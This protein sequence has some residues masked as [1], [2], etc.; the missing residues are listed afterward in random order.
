[1]DGEAEP[2]SGESTDAHLAGCVACRN[3]LQRAAV[4][5]RALRVRPASAVPDLAPRVLAATS[6][7]R[8]RRGLG[9]RIAL[10]CVAVAQFGLG[11]AEALGWSTGMGHSGQLMGGMSAHLFNESTCWNLALAAGLAWVAW[12]ADS[13]G[14]LLPVFGGF[15]LLLTGYCVHDLVTGD[16]TVARVASHGLLV[17]GFVLM[18]VVDRRYGRSGP[19]HSHRGRPRGDLPTGA[20]GRGLDDVQTSEQADGYVLR[21]VNRHHAA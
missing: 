11:A 8:R 5:N 18:V 12:R 2:V 15:L 21:P 1:M 20:D 13:V 19:P 6:T 3:W 9:W 14:G 17:V 4:L 7:L 16:A 10:A